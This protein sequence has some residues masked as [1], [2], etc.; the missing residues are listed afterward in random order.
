MAQLMEM[1]TEHPQTAA[2]VPLVPAGPAF[3]HLRVHSEYSIVDGLVRIDDVVGSHHD[4]GVRR[5]LMSVMCFLDFQV[6]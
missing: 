1:A 4:I 6:S 3:V 2:A 5:L